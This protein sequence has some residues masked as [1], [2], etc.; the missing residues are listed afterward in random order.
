MPLYYEKP[1]YYTI[2]H[3]LI[4]ALAYYYYEL[5]ALY[6]IYQFA[7]LYLGKRFFLFQWKIENGNSLVHTLIT[8]GEFMIGLLGV[9]SINLDK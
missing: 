9:Y 3:I 4:G 6:L 8:I 7:Q 5:G 1:F 2:I